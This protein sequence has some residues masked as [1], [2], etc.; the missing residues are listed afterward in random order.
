MTEGYYYCVREIK[1]SPSRTPNLKPLSR[2]FL[3]KQD[4]YN[5][6]DFCKTEEPKCKEEFF[7]YFREQPL[8]DDH[9]TLV[10]KWSKRNRRSI[11]TISK[12]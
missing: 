6:L 10:T 3:I 11:R 2:Q 9:R 5:W 4:A 12:F 7:V 8:S 1:C